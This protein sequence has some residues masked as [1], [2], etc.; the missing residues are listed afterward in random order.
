M[1]AFDSWAALI[2]P[3][4]KKLVREELEGL[5]QEAFVDAD[6][7]QDIRFVGTGKF[8]IWVRTTLPWKVTEK[9]LKWFNHKRLQDL[10]AIGSDGKYKV[11][12][13]FSISEA[14]TEKESNSATLR[15]SL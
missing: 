8:H 12:F 3:G 13:Y 9:R 7:G 1:I 14:P 15:L 11:E 4:L 2:L 6:I 5:F 10:V